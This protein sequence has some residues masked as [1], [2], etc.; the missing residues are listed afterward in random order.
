MLMLLLL[1]LSLLFKGRILYQVRGKA[2]VGDSAG[3]KAFDLPQYV[4]VQRV[5]VVMRVFRRCDDGRWSMVC[6]GNLYG[7]MDRWMDVSSC[8]TFRKLND[9]GRH[10][11]V[12]AAIARDSGGTGTGKMVADR[13]RDCLWYRFTLLH[14]SPHDD[15]AS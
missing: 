10:P 15:H 14:P 6:S 8:A 3:E 7:Q 2:D 9:L 4:T 13:V 1:L 5:T 12:I 11:S